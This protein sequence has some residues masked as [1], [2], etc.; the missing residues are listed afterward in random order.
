MGIVLEDVLVV[1]FNTSDAG[2]AGGAG[3]DVLIGGL[4]GDNSG[5]GGGKSEFAEFTIVKTTDGALPDGTEARSGMQTTEQGV[6]GMFAAPAATDGAKGGNIEFEWKVEEGESSGDVFGFKSMQ[7]GEAPAGT[8]PP[9]VTDMVIDGFDTGR[10]PIDN[11]GN[12]GWLYG[13]SGDGGS[14]AAGFGGLYYRYGND[15]L[16]TLA[17]DPNGGAGGAGGLLFGSGGAGIPVTMAE[18]GLMIA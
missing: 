4:G 12:A 10:L 17:P 18:Y 16:A 9:S 14:A 13:T 5:P 1:G 6:T 8:H 15:D 7:A 2:S 11:G 3:R